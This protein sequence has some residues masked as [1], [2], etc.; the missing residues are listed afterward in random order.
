MYWWIHDLWGPANLV[1]STVT[2]LYDTLPRFTDV[3]WDCVWATHGLP[4]EVLAWK[5]TLGWGRTWPDSLI[6]IAKGGHLWCLRG[7]RV[8]CYQVISLA[9][10]LLIRISVTPSDM[11]EAWSLRPNV[12]M[13]TTLLVCWIYLDDVDYFVVMACCYFNHYLCYLC[14]L[15]IGC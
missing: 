4:V 2:E 12:E 5:T 6:V 11:G 15:S 9:R 10:W 3:Q 8:S 7:S 14:M 13:G 1:A